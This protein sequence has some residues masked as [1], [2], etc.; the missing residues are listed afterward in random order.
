[1]VKL[2]SRKEICEKLNISEKTLRRK[3]QELNIECISE[4]LHNGIESKKIRYEDYLTIAN[5]IQRK[6][7]EVHYEN[8]STSTDLVVYQMKVELVKAQLNLDNAL[9]SI[10][11]KN[12]TI[13]K[14]EAMNGKLFDEFMELNRKYTDIL[15]ENKKG[16][17]ARILGK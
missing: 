8:E 11:E 10:E 17:F 2:L 15:S 14:L 6:P 3:I 12:D 5:A 9:K 7:N 1:M 13:G 4:T 16:F